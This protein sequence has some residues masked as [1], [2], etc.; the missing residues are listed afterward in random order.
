M[1]SNMPHCYCFATVVDYKLKQQT[2]NK[3]KTN[4]KGTRYNSL[5]ETCHGAAREGQRDAIDERGM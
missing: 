1:F 2:N 3:Q 4:S 5:K